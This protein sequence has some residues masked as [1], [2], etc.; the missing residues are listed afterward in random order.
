[1]SD[2]TSLQTWLASLG[3]YGYVLAA[4]V[5]VVAYLVRRWTG[6]PA[7]PV[8]PTP[9]PT[10]A[11]APPRLDAVAPLLNALLT[12]L[13]V[14]PRNRPATVAD[15]PHA[16]HLQL[17]DELDAVTAAKSAAHAAALADLSPRAEK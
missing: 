16:T 2:L 11:V 17:R 8:T 5:P 14:A 9:V 13:G 10:P 7:A 6:P 4:A 3:P 12:A 15:L 1:M